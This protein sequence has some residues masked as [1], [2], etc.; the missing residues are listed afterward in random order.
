MMKEAFAE[1]QVAEE[2]L[3]SPKEPSSKVA[4]RLA[5]QGMK[6]LRTSARIATDTW[7]HLK[8]SLA[9]DGGANEPIFP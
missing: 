2:L 6:H 4:Q 7:I 8:T 1:F 5:Q 3:L 9:E